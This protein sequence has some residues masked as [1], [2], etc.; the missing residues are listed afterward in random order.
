MKC[1]GCNYQI[2][3]TE[4]NFCPICGIELSQ[5]IG[6]RIN[7]EGEFHLHRIKTFW[8]K[9][10]CGKILFENFEAIRNAGEIGFSGFGDSPVRKQLGY[11]THTYLYNLRRFSFLY[12]SPNSLL[13]FYHIGKLIGYITASVG[14]PVFGIHEIL[15]VLNKT[16]KMWNIFGNNKVQ[17]AIRTAWINH[18]TA[19]PY[20]EEINKDKETITF[21][22]DESSTFI[23]NSIKPCCFG[24]MGALAGQCEALFTG[25]L[26]DS[27]EITCKC[28][29]DD[30]CIIEVYSHKKETTP[31]IELFEKNEINDIL[32]WVINSTVYRKPCNRPTLGNDYT[33]FAEQVINYILLTKTTGH[34]IIS[35]QSGI[36]VG[37]RISEKA[38]LKG[39]DK[40]LEYLQ[41][42]FLYLKAGIIQQ[43]ET[44]GDR[45]TIQM[46]ESVYS[47][48]VNNIGMKLDI[49]LAGIIEGVLC[50]ATSEKWQVSETKCLANGDEHCE[51]ICK[52]A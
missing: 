45:I 16:G 24:E 30:R 15:S 18:N 13:D 10:D 36:I 37:E 32:K 47:S 51:F 17:D 6:S 39:Q 43:P 52:K 29:G 4:Y 28:K 5:D 8:E 35:K 20:L 26:W 19:I 7:E 40:T 12:Y 48:G 22:L 44:S 49:F 34:Q 2:T 31:E 42:L 1:S 46:D 14:I 27:K 25:S 50:Q 41:D 21:R 38:E 33:I 3:N 9:D 23:H 11:L